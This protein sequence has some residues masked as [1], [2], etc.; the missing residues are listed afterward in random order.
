MERDGT[1][2]AH[3][4]SKKYVITKPKKKILNPLYVF[5]SSTESHPFI[6]IKNHIFPNTEM[7][8][9]NILRYLVNKQK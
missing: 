1:Y 3:T 8:F 5:G 6:L 4:S 7:K 9:V 2:R